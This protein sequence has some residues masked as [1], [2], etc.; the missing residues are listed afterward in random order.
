MRSTSLIGRPSFR[1][2]VVFPLGQ[3]GPFSC[4]SLYA[5]RLEKL[6]DGP[7]AADW[8]PAIRYNEK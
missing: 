1:F 7:I 2:P 6:L 8:D 5:M 4:P 3:G